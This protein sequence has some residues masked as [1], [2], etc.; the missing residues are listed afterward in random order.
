MKNRNDKNPIVLRKGMCASCQTIRYSPYVQ[1]GQWHSD[2]SASPHG[3]FKI[4]VKGV[5]R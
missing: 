2:C 5:K 1:Q 3:K 4:L